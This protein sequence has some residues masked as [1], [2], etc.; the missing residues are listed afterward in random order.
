MNEKKLRTGNVREDK[1][2]KDI[3]RIIFK[4]SNEGNANYIT[5]NVDNLDVEIKVDRDTNNCKL[6]YVF[7]IERLINH[8]ERYPE[9]KKLIIDIIKDL[10]SSFVGRVIVHMTVT[11]EY[12]M[13]FM[14]SNFKCLYINMIPFGD[15]T[16]KQYHMTIVNEGQI[17]FSTSIKN[18]LNKDSVKSIYVFEEKDSFKVEETPFGK[19]MSSGGMGILEQLEANGAPMPRTARLFGSRMPGEPIQEENR[20]NEDEIEF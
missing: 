8:A 13:K 1:T 14:K 20:E 6:G 10:F 4:L 9:K 15:D 11:S 16:G 18:A 2:Y 5:I 17:K 12:H 3:D 7:G 19:K